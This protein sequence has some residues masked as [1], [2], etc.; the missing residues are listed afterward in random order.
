MPGANNRC[1]SFLQLPS[2]RANVL[3]IQIC[4]ALLLLC[5]HTDSNLTSCFAYLLPVCFHVYVV[6]IVFFVVRAA[7]SIPC[8]RVSFRAFGDYD[9]AGRLTG[10]TL[11]TT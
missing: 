1:A 11:R 6:S 9:A 5:N 2:L 10:F 4:C 7:S 8:G 3:S